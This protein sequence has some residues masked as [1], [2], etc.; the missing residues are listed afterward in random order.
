[1]KIRGVFKLISSVAIFMLI[2]SLIAMVV[3][4]LWWLFPICSQSFMFSGRWV[5][6]VAITSW[7]LV[8]RRLIIN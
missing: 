3:S 1:M 4:V 5:I 7:L 8:T 6:S 2:C